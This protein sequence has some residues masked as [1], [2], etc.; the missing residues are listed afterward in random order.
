M[1]PF[2]LYLPTWLEQN[3]LYHHKD[4][5][6]AQAGPVGE[7]PS[8]HSHLAAHSQPDLTYFSTMASASPFISK[9][10]VPQVH[11]L[12]TLPPSGD[13]SA[14]LR[15]FKIKQCVEGRDG[16]FP[17]FQNQESLK[18]RPTSAIDFASQRVL[19]QR[20]EGEQTN[21][22]PHSVLGQLNRSG[23]SKVMHVYSRVN[24]KPGNCDHQTSDSGMSS[25]SSTA[26]RQLAQAFPQLI[27][28]DKRLR[29]PVIDGKDFLLD[30]ENNE[31]D[32][33]RTADACSSG[34]SL[35]NKSGSCH[36][37]DVHDETDHSEDYSQEELVASL[38]RH[39]GGA[40]SDSIL[41]VGG[42]AR[43]NTL[44]TPVRFHQ[45]LTPKHERKDFADKQERDLGRNMK[46][47][48]TGYHGVQT[49]VE[50]KQP[51][52]YQSNKKG[53]HDGDGH[54]SHKEKSSVQM[55]ESKKVP[56]HQPNLRPIEVNAN[57]SCEKSALHLLDENQNRATQATLRTGRSHHQDQEQENMSAALLQPEVL[58]ESSSNDVRQEL[59]VQECDTSLQE[60][61][62]S[63]VLSRHV[64][65]NDFVNSS[66]VKMSQDLKAKEKTRRLNKNAMNVSAENLHRSVEDVSSSSKKK[67]FRTSLKNLFHRKK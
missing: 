64:A 19:Q 56:E 24:L 25:S 44:S 67:A 26:R 11:G 21:V 51:V 14:R 61:G 17:P 2:S 45:H 43:H 37:Q 54:S 65:A 23:G 8:L 47:T 15:R 58:L 57:N 28:G 38:S 52:Q 50:I 9:E 59:C 63:P 32:D 34:A 5:S 41:P 60:S 66:D 33:T 7:E 46:H 31:E 18:H 6:R 10:T 30:Y 13:R 48:L 62:T 20:Q 4:T 16:Y 55:K 36:S 3:A 12:S 40:G 35:S 22:R 1:I 29:N 27:I 53:Y 49:N 42:K 39:L